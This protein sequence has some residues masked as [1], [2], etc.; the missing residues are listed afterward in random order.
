[1]NNTEKIKNQAL[2]LAKQFKQ[3][4]DCFSSMNFEEKSVQEWY[5]IT[6]LAQVYYNLMQGE[7]TREQATQQQKQA[8]DIVSNHP[9]LFEVMDDE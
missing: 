9:E 8:F 4:E 5:L 2:E 7:I 6:T 3:N 1:M